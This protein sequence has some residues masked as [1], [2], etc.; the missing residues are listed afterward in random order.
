MFTGFTAIAQ[1]GRY[2]EPVDTIP[3]GGQAQE[4]KSAQ[5][6]AHD[7]LREQLASLRDS[8]PVE[9]AVVSDAQR[10]ELDEIISHLR[11]T[12]RSPEVMKRGYILLEEIRTALRPAT[13]AKNRQS[14]R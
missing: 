2:E 14:E 8:I 9:S 13:P 11:K 5:M 1:V 3:I 7:R 6:E 12:E 10:K 4:I